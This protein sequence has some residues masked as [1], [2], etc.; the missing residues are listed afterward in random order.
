MILGI[1]LIMVTDNLFLLKILEFND[2]D[3]ASP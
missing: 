2:N 1:E 3:W